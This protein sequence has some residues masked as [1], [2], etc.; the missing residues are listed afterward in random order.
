MQQP[1]PSPLVVGVL[2]VTPDSFS[3]GGRYLDADA[4][5]RHG[6]ALVAQG[7]DLIDVGGESTR[8]GATPVPPEEELRRVLPVVTGLVGAGVRIS[9]DTRHAAVAQGA[10]IAGAALVND[11]D[12]GAGDPG[13]LAVV[14][15]TDA[16]YV[17]MHS[18]GP[19]A[20]SGRY[21]D[22]VEDVAAELRRRV[23]AARAAGI[24]DDRLIIDPGI[25]FAKNAEENWR[26]LGAL[27]RLRVDDLRLLVGASRKRFL[28]PLVPGGAPAEARDLP[29]AVLSALLAER[30][31]WAVRVHDVASTRTALD[32]VR[33][34]RGAA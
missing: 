20:A 13:M 30:G 18:H 11:V 21:G 22:V 10:V 3:D 24:P 27:E 31:V 19:A 29:T 14:A 17:V 28:A 12:G 16:E 1:P 9:I 33:A 8:P 23:A 2:N 26:L 34:I 6:L 15:A 4:A 7:A 32:V 5:I 25:G